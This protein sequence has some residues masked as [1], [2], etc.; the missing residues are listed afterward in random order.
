MSA[1]LGTSGLRLVEPLPAHLDE[2]MDDRAREQ[3]IAALV[4]RYKAAAAFGG[5]SKCAEIHAQLMA[6]CGKRSPAQKKRMDA[7]RMARIRAGG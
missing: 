6:E 1:S 7:D 3:R 5:V 4:T 2:T